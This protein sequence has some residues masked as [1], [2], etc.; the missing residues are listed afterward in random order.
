[1]HWIRGHQLLYAGTVIPIQADREQQPQQ[2]GQTS[3]KLEKR[4]RFSLTYLFHAG[5]ADQTFGNRI[6]SNSNRSIDF[7]WVRESNL[8]ELA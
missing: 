7:D 3:K 6:Q 2:P 1:M 8:T 5:L 4:S